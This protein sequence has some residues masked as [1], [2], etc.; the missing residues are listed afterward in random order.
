MNA[1]AV[2]CLQKSFCTETG[3]QTEKRGMEWV[4]R[5]NVLQS[6]LLLTI[7]VSHIQYIRYIHTAVISFYRYATAGEANSSIIITC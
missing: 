5:L 6:H 3:V 1:R 2:I 4:A 7:Y